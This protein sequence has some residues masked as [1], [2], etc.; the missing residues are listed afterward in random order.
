MSILAE[1]NGSQHEFERSSPTLE[2]EFR[3][4]DRAPSNMDGQT[5]HLDAQTVRSDGEKIGMSRRKT[6]MDRKMIGLGR[7]ADTGSRMRSGSGPKSIHMNWKSFRSGDKSVRSDETAV[8]MTRTTIHITR[9]TNCAAT[10]V[11]H[12]TIHTDR[13]RDPYGKRHRKTPKRRFPT[14]PFFSAPGSSFRSNPFGPLYL[15]CLPQRSTATLAASP[16]MS[17][18][19]VAP[20]TAQ[21]FHLRP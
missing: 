14:A 10:D 6:D 15:G 7:R 11:D 20:F 16:D 19:P 3:R 5:V 18:T 21:D 17:L 8:G 4:V 13:S 12:A 9:K 1:T 2:T